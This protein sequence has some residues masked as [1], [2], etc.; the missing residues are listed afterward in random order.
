MK[1]TDRSIEEM[2]S[3]VLRLGVTI[4][5]LIVLGGGIYYLISHGREH[6][7]Y[8]VF[9]GADSM[10]RTLPGILHGVLAR[11]SRSIIQ[12]GLLTLILTPILRVAFSLV[13]FALE[14]DRKFVVITSIVL[15]VLIYS[16]VNGQLN[17]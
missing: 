17:G 11:R 16:L 8:H 13:G 1:V 5:G 15:A 14:R 10:D 2:V 9:A 6:E 3:V 4:S 7:P 12:L